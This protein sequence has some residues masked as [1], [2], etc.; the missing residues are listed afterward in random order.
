MRQSKE[1][2]FQRMQSKKP[3]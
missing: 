1:R 2:F 3:F